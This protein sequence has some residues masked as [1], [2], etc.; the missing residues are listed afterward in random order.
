VT[1]Q[2]LHGPEIASPAIDQ[3]SFCPTQGVGAEVSRVQSDACC[4][5]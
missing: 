4:P 3:C 1:K 2:Q 5:A